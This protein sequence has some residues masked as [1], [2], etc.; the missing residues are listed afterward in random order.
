MAQNQQFGE[1]LWMPAEQ[2]RI[3][4]QRVD[5]AIQEISAK[6]HAVQSKVV[7]GLQ[8]EL[9]EIQMSQRSPEVFDGCVTGGAIRAQHNEIE[10]RVH[11][12][13][14]GVL[15]ARQLFQSTRGQHPRGR[16]AIGR[17]TWTRL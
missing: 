6:P 9:L 16:I 12:R 15:A 14:Y 2:R 4:M 11:P 3:H 10:Q 7:P 8:Q 13:R 5:Q 1:V 17:A